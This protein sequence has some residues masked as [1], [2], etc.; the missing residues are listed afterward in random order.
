[1]VVLLT[2]QILLADATSGDTS[3]HSS[4][5]P[6]QFCLVRPFHSSTSMRKTLTASLPQPS[7]SIQDAGE[8]LASAKVRVSACAV[9]HLRDSQLAPA[10]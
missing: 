8:R 6:L 5:Y 2:P 3:Q 10:L 9:R 7:A 1:M 4:A